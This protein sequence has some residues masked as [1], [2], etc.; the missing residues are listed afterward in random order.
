[1]KDP[2]IRYIQIDIADQTITAMDSSWRPVALPLSADGGPVMKWAKTSAGGF[3]IQALVR[4]IN[5]LRERGG[6]RL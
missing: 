1:M 2:N 5:N 6:G 4:M 3:V